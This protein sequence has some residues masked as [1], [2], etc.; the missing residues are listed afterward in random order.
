MP[1]DYTNYTTIQDELIKQDLKMC[2]CRS[3]YKTSSS[4]SQVVIFK[5][6]EIEGDLEI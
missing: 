6:G 5:P 1:M 4:D 3:T 2:F